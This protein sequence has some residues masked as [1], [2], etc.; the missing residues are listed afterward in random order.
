[1][2]GLA[3]QQLGQLQL[4]H[5]DSEA[6]GMRGTIGGWLG[7]DRVATVAHVGSIPRPSLA[8]NKARR[9]C[10]F[11][12]PIGVALPELQALTGPATAHA[13]SYARRRACLW[14]RYFG[15]ESG[16]CGGLRRHPL[17]ARFSPGGLPGLAPPRGGEPPPRDLSPPA[18]THTLFSRIPLSTTGGIVAKPGQ[19]VNP[20]RGFSGWPASPQPA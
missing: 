19:T 9:A 6:V 14:R 18:E 13:A 5:F 2:D 11:R 12:E 7:G 10:P 3:Q 17:I 16:A 4:P 1:M 20:G 15:R 8:R